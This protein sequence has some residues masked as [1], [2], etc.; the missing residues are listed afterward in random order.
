[1]FDEVEARFVVAV[2]ELAG[3]F[4]GGGAVG[5]VEGFGAEPLDADDGDD[6]VGEDAADG[7]VGVEVFEFQGGTSALEMSVLLATKLETVAP[8]GGPRTRSRCGANSLPRRLDEA[9]VS[10]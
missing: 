7:G 9:A 10:F 2:K 3:E 6:S 8:G 1:M 4:A 5:K